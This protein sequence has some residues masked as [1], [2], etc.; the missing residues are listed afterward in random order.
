MLIEKS[1]ILGSAQAVTS[2]AASDVV[3]QVVASDAI[4]RAPFLQFLVT[5]SFTAAG[6]ATMQLELQDSADNSSFSTVYITEAIP[7]AT[8]VAGYKR[9]FRLPPGLRRY[10]RAN[11]TVA[12]G[13]M[14]AGNITAQLV[15]DVDVLP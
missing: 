15:Q 2:S 3:D 13:P 8:L 12:T 11:Y 10:F 5:T 14:T 9:N 7:K 6:S 4:A 1:T